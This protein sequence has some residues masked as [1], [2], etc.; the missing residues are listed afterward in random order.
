MKKALFAGSFDPPTLG[1]LNIITRALALCDELYIAVAQNEDKKGKELF[2]F[3][4]RKQLLFTLTEDIPSTKVVIIEHLVSSYA[5]KE[6]IDFLIRSLRTSSEL[7]YEKTLAEKNKSLTGIETVFLFA[8][9]PFAKLSSS[10]VRKALRGKKNISHIL[11]ISIEKLAR[12][13]LTK[14]TT[15]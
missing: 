9:D 8:E 13:F 10:E 12:D 1:H 2:S 6:G 15:A 14:K 7:L 3:E 5:K 11:P 4:E